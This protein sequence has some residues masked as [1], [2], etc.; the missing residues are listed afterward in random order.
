MREECHLT[1]VLICDSNATNDTEAM[2]K[3]ETSSVLYLAW[4]S[5]PDWSIVTAVL[6]C[7]RL[8]FDLCSIVGA[9]EDVVDAAATPFVQWPPSLL[10]FAVSFGNT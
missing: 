7:I 5:F 2:G 4:L 10:I 8:L 6:H 3:H 9:C 1:A